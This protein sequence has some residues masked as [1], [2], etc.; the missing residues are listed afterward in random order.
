M[1]ERLNQTSRKILSK[2]PKLKDGINPQ[3]DC[4]RNIECIE[5][6]EH[7]LKGIL[8]CKVNSTGCPSTIDRLQ[9][10]LER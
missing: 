9:L 10:K 3:R 2:E 5:F 4:V 7:N 6:L 1:V 8:F